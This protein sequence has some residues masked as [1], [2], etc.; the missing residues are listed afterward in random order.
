MRV[1]TVVHDLGHGGTQRVAQ[2]FSL[3]FQQAGHEVAVLAY[4]DGGPRAAPLQEAGISVFIGQPDEQAATEQ[5]AHWNPDLVHIH[6]EGKADA[7][8]A[9][10]LKILKALTAKPPRV[11]ET[12]VFAWPDYSADG[13]LI[14][15]HMPLTRWCLWKWKQWTRPI[16]PSP[17][18]VVIPNPSNADA[19]YPE[20]REVAERFRKEHS[21]PIDAVV[22]GRLGQPIPDKWSPVAL[23]A[24][25]EIAKRHPKAHLLLVGLPDE[26][27]SLVASYPE[28]IRSRI[29][30]ISF[31]HGDEAL[32]ACYNA[33]DVFIHAAKIGESFGMVLT[34]ALLCECP[35]ITLS[36]PHYSNSQLEVVGHEVGG[37]AVS[38]EH[39][40]A[41]AME[42]LLQ[43]ESRRTQL[44]Q[45]GRQRV[46]DR[47]VTSAV[48]PNLLRI[49]EIASTAPDRE[50]MRQALA[51]DEHLISEVSNAFIKTSL[52]QI[53]GPTPLSEK[54][55]MHL[56][57]NPY[58]Y[59]LRNRW[60]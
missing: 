7:R 27:R 10:L 53:S 57:H 6:R 28:N 51:N 48:M 54:M 1:L 16:T 4:A 31:L 2:N 21:L 26:L 60:T 40:F 44:G 33:L 56:V 49:A 12:N 24:F 29:V 3:G 18:G 55:L 9:T 46:L 30:E 5:A 35:V 14:D 17:L 15:V 47:Y 8:A 43:N 59:R 50:H 42:S 19:F 13:A 41:K 38:N 20:P 11:I 37:L 36:T 45:K 32:R 58:L 25:A 52:A 39:H 34:E 22:F 23:N